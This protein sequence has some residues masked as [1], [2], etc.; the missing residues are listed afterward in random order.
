[1]TG[2][3]QPA[4]YR[5]R[6]DLIN[7][8][9]LEYNQTFSILTLHYD[10][11]WELVDQ[12]GKYKRKRDKIK[13]DIL[14]PEEMDQIIEDDIEPPYPYTHWWEDVSLED[15]KLQG[16]YEFYPMKSK[17]GYACNWKGKEIK[18]EMYENKKGEEYEGL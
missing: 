12:K 15:M 17:L 14:N 10:V 4:S 5:A 1:M 18:I 3:L 9:V 16:E 8:G 11:L 2:M 6:K 13:N 7:T